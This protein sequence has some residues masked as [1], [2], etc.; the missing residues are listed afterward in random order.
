MGR[1]KWLGWY[2]SALSQLAEERHARCSDLSASTLGACGGGGAH[3]A[4]L[5]RLCRPGDRVSRAGSPVDLLGRMALLD[6]TRS[7]A[8][9]VRVL[10][11]SSLEGSRR[12]ADLAAASFAS[13]SAELVEAR[14]M[15]TVVV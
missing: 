6:R 2:E 4:H 1:G 12:G 7:S 8:C 3:V 15:A 11:Q 5:G 13:G 14:R 9:V 10:G